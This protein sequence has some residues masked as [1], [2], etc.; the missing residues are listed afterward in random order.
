MKLEDVEGTLVVV[1]ILDTTTMYSG[2]MYT[3]SMLRGLAESNE[4]M[5]FDVDEQALFM[6]VEITDEMREALVGDDEIVE[7]I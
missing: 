4:H 1:R 2:M 3:E 6:N 5:F 7:E